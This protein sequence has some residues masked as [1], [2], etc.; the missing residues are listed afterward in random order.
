[1]F[2]TDRTLPIVMI[3]PSLQR[4]TKRG[5]PSINLYNAGTKYDIATYPS[6]AAGAMMRHKK[7]VLFILDGSQLSCLILIPRLFTSILKVFYILPSIHLSK[8]ESPAKSFCA[9]RQDHCNI[10]IAPNTLWLANPTATNAVFLHDFLLR[11]PLET[12]RLLLFLGKNVH[13]CLV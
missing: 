13:T 8:R 3:H 12:I 11:R 7:S 10:S 2:S 4:L 9:C 5:L 1:M 6:S